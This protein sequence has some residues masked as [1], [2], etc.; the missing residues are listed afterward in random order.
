V[1]LQALLQAHNPAVSR[2]AG[3]VYVPVAMPWCGTFHSFCAEM[4]RIHGVF[5]ALPS[6]WVSILFRLLNCSRA[7][8]SG[9]VIGVPP[10]FVI[11]DDSDQ[12]KVS[13]TP[14]PPLI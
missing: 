5:T 9:S 11:L 1:R 3:M 4:L 8:V 13:D 7:N 10:G 6:T 2:G 12:R 14:V